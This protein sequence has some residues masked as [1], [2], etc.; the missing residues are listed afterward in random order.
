MASMKNSTWL[1]ILGLPALLITA[2]LLL[3]RT[4]PEETNP[5]LAA[6]PPAKFPTP[7]ARVGSPPATS[8]CDE[9]LTDRGR[10][11]LSHIARGYRNCDVAEAL[12]IA[13]STV[14][15]H[16]KAIYRKL[17]ISSRAEAS[18]HATRFGRRLDLV[19]GDQ[20]H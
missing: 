18:W 12:G 15:S 8:A 13:E 4:P 6:S 14:A 5:P 20:E 19:D 3:G 10:E 2:A 7:I 17:G 9:L 11:T 1:G 16:I